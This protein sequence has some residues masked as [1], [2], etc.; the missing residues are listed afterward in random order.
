MEKEDEKRLEV[1]YAKRDSG[2]SGGNRRVEEE[3]EER[4]WTRK[5]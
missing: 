1:L 5:K 3:E 2:S 4:G